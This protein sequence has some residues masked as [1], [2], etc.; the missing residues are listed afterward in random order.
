[1]CCLDCFC[2]LQG[3]S[4]F[5]I[6]KIVARLVVSGDIYFCVNCIDIVSCTLLL[7]AEPETIDLGKVYDFYTSD[8]IQRN[9]MTSIIFQVDCS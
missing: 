8:V 4:F 6:C 1:M 3:R 5:V 2:T 9:F 7:S